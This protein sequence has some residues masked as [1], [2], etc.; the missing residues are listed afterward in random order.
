MQYFLD[1]QNQIWAYEDYVPQEE[2]KEGLTPITNEEF[3]RLTTPPPPSE[4]ELLELAKQEKLAEIRVKRDSLLEGSIEY[5]GHI[6]QTR[7]KDKL[8][9]NGAVTNLMLDIQS[10]QNSISEIIWIDIHDERVSFTPNDFLIFASSV[11]YQTQEITFKANTLKAS[12]ET[13]KSVEEV[14]KIIW[15]G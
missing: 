3:E 1:S 6:F 5:K 13:A 4:E 2:I 11:A 8:N 14:Q 7:E 10:G 15:E 9:I 12:I